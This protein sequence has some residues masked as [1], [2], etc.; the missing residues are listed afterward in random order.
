MKK[1]NYENYYWQNDLVRLRALKEEDWEESYY[2]QFDSKA[3]VMLQYELELPPVE[4][5]VK[6][7]YSAFVGFKPGTG[8]LMFA[9]EN[10][11]GEFVGSFNLN[12]IDEKNGTF[13]IGMQMSVGQ[14]GKG[15]G[16]AAMRI[17]LGYAFFERRLNKYN[18]SVIQW[19]VGSATMLK[20]V[21]CKQ[22]GIRRQ[23]IYTDGHYVDEILYGL[24]KED[25]I[26]N[27][28]KLNRYTE[29][30]HVDLGE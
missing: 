2:N 4:E 27:E 28:E 1:I 15:Y 30:E 24:T 11:E 10:L 7:S 19:N 16:T 17:L 25:F 8:R 5:K 12:S 29:K 13:S 14:R 6:E 9:I 26:A 3:R 23:N 20:K 18:G 22:E 21:G